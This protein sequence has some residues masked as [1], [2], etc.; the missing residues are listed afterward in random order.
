[1]KKYIL[2][3]VFGAVLSVQSAHANDWDFHANFGLTTIT[4]PLYAGGNSMGTAFLPQVD[5]QY[6]P[7]ILH[8]FQGAGLLLPLE[9]TRTLVVNPA[10]RWRTTRNLSGDQRDTWEFIQEMRPVAS[11]NTILN[12]DPVLFS[13]RL[14]E[15]IASDNRGS[16][17]NFGITFRDYVA[18][19]LHL[20]VIGTA[21]YGFR[22][23]MQTYFGINQWQSDRYGFDVHTPSAGWRSVGITVMTKYHMTDTWSLTFMGEYQRLIDVAAN[24]EITRDRNQFMVGTGMVRR[25]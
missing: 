4:L 23:Y 17:A 18:Q 3:L 13:V 11:F 21:V 10:I 2:P 8:T 22:E 12:F 19:N 24:S 1:M 16:T 20:T 14:A 15:G 9:S 7:F 5:V 6:G 25:F